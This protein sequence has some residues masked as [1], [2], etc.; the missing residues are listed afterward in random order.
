[1]KSKLNE[2]FY[3]KNVLIL[4]FGLEGHSTLN[5]LKDIDCEITI[6]D[7]KLQITPDI[8][9]YNLIT[10]E[11]YLSHLNDFDIIMKSPGIALKNDVSD[12]VKKKITSQTDLLLRFCDSKIIGV[13]GTKGKS[14]TSSLIYHFLRACGKDTMLIGNIGVP[15]LDKISEIKP[16]TVIVCEMSC[17]QLEYV[18]A[19]P[20]IA[21][22]LNIYPEHLDHYAS[23]SDYK[24]AKQNIFMYQNSDDVLI[25]N[26][27][28][29]CDK[30]NMKNMKKITASFNIPCD[31]FID[32]EN[33]KVLDLYIPLEQI[34]TTLKGNHNL[35][36]IGIALACVKEA[37]CDID[38]AVASL[39]SF[40]GLEHRLEYV[41]NINGVEYINDSI[42]TVPQTV[43]AAV[44]AFDSVDTL[45]LGGMDRGISYDKLT[46]FL[47]KGVVKNI[48]VMPDSGFRIADKLD[49]SAV[50]VFPVSNMIEAVSKAKEVAT[51]R[52]ILS[53]AA[54]SYGFYKNFEERGR[55]FKQLI[56]S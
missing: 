51:H 52:C 23:F 12:E 6:A 1:M 34:N 10:G 45:I 48:I 37:G 16:D 29:I 9:V 19:S 39:P 4:G 55:D 7:R 32:G 28:C 41:G 24:A 38:F 35:F 8:E 53:P 47:N 36:N 2:F 54:A 11:N 40:K 20:N 26:M 43:I 22:L 5:V 30:M 56:L 13:T 25:A 21:V 14:T 44:K 18:K 42:S 17:H 50:N 31:V 33:L 27:E 3:K 49:R 46:D 15:P